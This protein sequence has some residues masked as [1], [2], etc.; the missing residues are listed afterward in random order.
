MVVGETV[1]VPAAGGLVPLL[2]VQTNGPA[3]EAVKVTVWPAQIIETEGVIEIGATGAMETVATAVAVQEPVPDN[4]VYVVV[5]LGVTVTVAAAG[6]F[7]PL[8]A[9]HVNGPAPVDVKVTLCPAQMVESE[10]VILIDN[11]AATD[12]VATAEVVHEPVPEITV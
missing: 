7:V 2:A 9:V 4:T 11:V 3:P 8:L 5:V 1:T 10:G 6:G 12:T